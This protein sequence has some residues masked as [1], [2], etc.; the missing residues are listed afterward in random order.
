MGFLKVVVLRKEFMEVIIG[1]WLIWIGGNYDGGMI[2]MGVYDLFE[3]F[4]W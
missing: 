4:G 1:W 2:E 3:E